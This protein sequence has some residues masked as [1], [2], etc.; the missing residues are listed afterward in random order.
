MRNNVQ[1]EISEFIRMCEQAYDTGCS[2]DVGNAWDKVSVVFG[3]V[4]PGFFDGLSGPD[5][6]RGDMRLLDLPLI[7]AKLR[8]FSA[9]LDYDAAAAKK[10]PTSDMVPLTAAIEIGAPFNTAI[11]LIVD[12]DK[13]TGNEKTE[14]ISQINALKRIADSPFEKMVKWERV[15]PVL[16]W[17]DSKNERTA[18]IILPLAADAMK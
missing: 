14:I 6:P 13:F 12:D 16:A 5:S 4:I 11:E 8:I 18:A 3:K 17:L 1:E 10:E 9:K 15:R 2:E 7:K